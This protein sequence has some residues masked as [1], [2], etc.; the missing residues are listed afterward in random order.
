MTRFLRYHILHT[1][2]YWDVSSYARKTNKRITTGP[3]TNVK[4]LHAVTLRSHLRPRCRIR[5]NMRGKRFVYFSFRGL[6]GTSTNLHVLSAYQRRLSPSY[7]SKRRPMRSRTCVHA[8]R[9][10]ARRFEG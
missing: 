5:S 9:S 6:L 7:R 4:R 10:V 2:A 8:H 3:R 1:V